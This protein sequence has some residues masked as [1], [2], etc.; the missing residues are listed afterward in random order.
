MAQKNYFEGVGHV[1][2][3]STD[4]SGPCEHCPKVV[5]GPVFAESV[6][7]Y[8]AEHKYKV[9]HVGAETS[10]DLDGKP[11]HLTVAVLGR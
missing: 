1:V 10:R 2:H 3:I 8:I 9:L 6:N 4:V 7:H 11:W 5:G